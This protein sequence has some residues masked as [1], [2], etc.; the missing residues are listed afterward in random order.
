MIGSPV[1]CQPELSP[2]GRAESAPDSFGRRWS[3]D[4][5]N[6]GVD[7]SAE[8]GSVALY[9][10]IYTSTS[11]KYFGGSIWAFT[12]YFFGMSHLHFAARFYCHF[13]TPPGLTRS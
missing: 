13:R 1:A 6:L 12:Q 3:G 11:I 7:S 8:G 9:T 5:Q 10:L 2:K 4:I